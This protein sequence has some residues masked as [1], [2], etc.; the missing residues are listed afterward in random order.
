MRHHVNRQAFVP[1]LKSENQR[2]RAQPVMPQNSRIAQ[3]MLSTAYCWSVMKYIGQ[4]GRCLNVRLKEPKTSVMSGGGGA[5]LPA[6][7]RGCECVPLF[8]K[9]QII[10]NRGAIKCERELIEAYQ[11]RKPGFDKCTSVPSL[12]VSGKEA[13]YLKKSR[14]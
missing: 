5:N 1:K 6:H 7:C 2:T 4:T 9:T 13:E 3:Q 11:M 14:Y 12:T 8:D 10:G